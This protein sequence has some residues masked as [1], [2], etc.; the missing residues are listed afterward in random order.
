MNWKSSRI[1]LVL[2]ACLLIGWVQTTKTTVCS[3]NL[4]PFI[5]N[6]V[7][8]G[9][10]LNKIPIKYPNKCGTEWKVYGSCCEV[11]SLEDYAIKD[12]ASFKAATVKLASEVKNNIGMIGLSAIVAV[13]DRQ[14]KYDKAP[15]SKKAEALVKL[16]EAKELLSKV[17]KAGD[18]SA[19]QLEVIKG[20]KVCLDR[21]AKLRSASFCNT[22]AKRSPRFFKDGKALMSME[23]CKQTI[24]DCHDYWFALITIIDNLASIEDLILLFKKRFENTDLAAKVETN[25]MEFL[26]KWLESH[27]LKERFEGCPSVSNCSEESASAICSSLISIRKQS[28]ILGA[29]SKAATAEAKLFK[30]TGTKSNFGNRRMLNGDP[31]TFLGSMNV[32]ISVIPTGMQLGALEAVM[33]FNLQFP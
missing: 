20:D 8:G 2:V 24:S 7:S 6:L 31:F 29:V 26:H 13:G 33:N 11:Q 17:I 5:K 28:P 18:G 22:C 27:K 3:K 14:R 19:K 1:L 25:G 12:M 4:N 16:N 10:E 23:T 15:T 21:L 30:T 32:D 9:V